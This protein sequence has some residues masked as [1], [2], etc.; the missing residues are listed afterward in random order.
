M[1]E[2]TEESGRVRKANPDRGRA[3]SQTTS[4]GAEFDKSALSSCN[5]NAVAFGTTC[6][7]MF[8][9][10]ARLTLFHNVRNDK[11]HS[12]TPHLQSLP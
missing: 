10:L 11:L 12:I 5:S 1:V 4:K 2:E 7:V 6:S 9:L 8:Q 3:K